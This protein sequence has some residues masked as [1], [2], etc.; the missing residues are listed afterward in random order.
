MATAIAERSWATEMLQDVAVNA[1]I[2][3]PGVS[4]STGDEEVSA[5]AA[6]LGLVRQAEHHRRGE[7]LIPKA[8]ASTKL[9]GQELAIWQ[10]YCPTHYVDGTE[11]FKNYQL[12][13]IPVPV[14][15]HWKDVKGKF[16]F[17]SYEI[18]TA[19]RLLRRVGDPLLIGI[20]Q[21]A[22]YLIARWGEEATDLISFE[23]V[24]EHVLQGLRRGFE[25]SLL[26]QP[27]GERIRALQLAENKP[28]TVQYY[29]YY[30]SHRTGL[31]IPLFIAEMFARRHCG[32]PLSVFIFDYGM[33]HNKYIGICSSCGSAQEVPTSQ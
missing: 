11:E 18:W 9:S 29:R 10:M 6:E 28:A 8:F 7:H 32:K 13:T 27:I 24:R 33:W 17:D 30:W 1:R 14:L 15:R 3:E 4:E 19:E 20:F 12:D 22:Q 21:K 26:P 23:E 25:I 31:P 16:P 2:A 5:I